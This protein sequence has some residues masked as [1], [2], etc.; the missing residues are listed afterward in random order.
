[1]KA[2]NSPWRFVMRGA[3]T[4]DCACV[5]GMFFKIAFAVVKLA[6]TAHCASAETAC[7]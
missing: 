4:R 7:P 6:W 1:M 3:E 5:A 2:K